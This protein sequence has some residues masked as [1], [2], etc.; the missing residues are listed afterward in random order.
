MRWRPP[1]FDQAVLEEEFVGRDADELTE[2]L[3]GRGHPVRRWDAEA[4]N[5]PSH[6]PPMWTADRRPNRLN[7]YVEQGHVVKAFWG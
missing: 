7:I 2:Q 3:R 4:A 1:F 6:P 5:D